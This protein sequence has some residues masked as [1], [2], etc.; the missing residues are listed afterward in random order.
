MLDRR[1]NEACEYPLL[2]EGIFERAVTPA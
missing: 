2:G 1:S